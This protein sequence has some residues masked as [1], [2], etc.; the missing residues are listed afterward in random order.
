[1][2]G[3]TLLITALASMAIFAHAADGKT[4][5]T[6]RLGWATPVNGDV[7]DA[8]A[9]NGFF[10]GF[11]YLN[12]QTFLFE[13][14]KSTLEFTWM[15]FGSRD[16]FD[17]YSLMYV[18]R[19]KPETGFYY[20]VGAGLAYHDIN[21]RGA[22]GSSILDSIASREVGGPG[23]TSETALRLAATALIGFNVSDKTSL[24]LF[25]FYSGSVSGSSTD[26]FGLQYSIRF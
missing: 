15:R 25:Y 13:G 3:K 21:V 5:S 8:T 23:G 22:G 24:E 2:K 9:R 6:I 7:R 10:V 1:M 20:G 19:S 18:E 4:E 14:G 12:P 11:G 16:R 26:R 17:S